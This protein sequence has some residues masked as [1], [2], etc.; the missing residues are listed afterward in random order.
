MLKAV[1]MIFIYLQVTE[2]LRTSPLTKYPGDP[3]LPLCW[4]GP[5]GY[6]SV[7]EVKGYFR[8]FA[9]SFPKAENVQFQLPPEAYLIISV[10]K[11][12]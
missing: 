3:Y 5:K 4:K 10:S 6:E 2:N 1:L 7:D 8:N 12:T 11:I 9:I